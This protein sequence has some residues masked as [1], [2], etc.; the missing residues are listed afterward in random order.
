MEPHI[1]A[2]PPRR[3]RRLEEDGGAADI[4]VDEVE[5]TV[6]GA[7]DVAFSREVDH[8]VDR[9]LGEDTSHCVGIPDVGVNEE[10]AVRVCR[11]HT[12]EARQMAGVGQSID[13]DQPHVIVGRQREANEVRS[14]K[15][16]ATGDQD[17][18][19]SVECGRHG[20]NSG[21]SD[22]GTADSGDHLRSRSERF[23]SRP[24][25]GQAMA[26]SGSSHGRPRS[27]SAL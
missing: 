13:V 2:V 12:F 25:S 6:D 9:V 27:S 26:I 20:S 17:R 18:P 15:A 4:G 22:S 24:A 10:V 23:G 3:P 16:G 14:D 21:R 8:R 1:L 11:A 19:R 5:R 7:I